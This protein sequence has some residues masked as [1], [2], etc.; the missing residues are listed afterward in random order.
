V[1]LV[2]RVGEDPVTV[3]VPVLFA[4]D[5]IEIVKETVQSPSD[6]V[7]TA[8]PGFPETFGGKPESETVIGCAT[9]A[10]LVIVIVTTPGDVLVK[11]SAEGDALI[12]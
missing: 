9:P 1:K 2:V 4:L 12:E 11:A 7:H 3:M 8:L 10:S 6:G 5:E